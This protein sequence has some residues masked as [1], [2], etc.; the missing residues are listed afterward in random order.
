MI[1][2]KRRGG[3]RLGLAIL[4]AAQEAKW[5]HAAIGGETIREF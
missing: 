3:P 5:I 2:P 1:R 4:A